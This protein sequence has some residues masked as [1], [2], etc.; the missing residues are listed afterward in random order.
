MATP[1]VTL[2]DGSDVPITSRNVTHQRRLSLPLL[3]PFPACSANQVKGSHQFVELPSETHPLKSLITTLLPKLKPQEGATYAKNL[4]T[5]DHETFLRHL[6]HLKRLATI[7]YQDPAAVD[8]IVDFVSKLLALKE[9]MT[10]D[11]S[12]DV[13]LVE[14]MGELIY[15]LDH[16]P[17][18]LLK[19]LDATHIFSTVKEVRSK[20]D[21]AI[22]E[23]QNRLKTTH[24][25]HTKTG[26]HNANIAEQ[27]A[28][29]TEIAKIL[30][31]TSGILNDALVSRVIHEFVQDPTQKMY[32][33]SSL[34]AG[35]NLIRHSVTIRE[36][37]EKITVRHPI[38][39]HTELVIASTL[40]LPP[41]TE[42][43]STHARQCALSALLTRLRQGMSGSC[44]A[45]FIAI[46]LQSA[47]PE[48]VLKDFQQLFDEQ[49][50]VRELDGV[51][52]SFPYL[53]H[54]GHE[55][56][57]Q[58]IAIDKRGNVLHPVSLNGSLADAPGFIAVCEQFHIDNPQKFLHEWLSKQNFSGSKLEITIEDL[59]GH[60]GREATSEQI[61][62]AQGAFT[63]FTSH[64]LLSIWE[65]SLAAMSEGKKGGLLQSALINTIVYPILKCGKLKEIPLQLMERIESL[66]MQRAHYLYD[67][68][69]REGA[70]ILYDSLGLD[71]VNQWERIDSQDAFKIFVQKL[72]TKV[73]ENDPLMQ[74]ISSYL[75]S[76]KF[77]TRIL[78]KYNPSENPQMVQLTPWITLL[79]NDPLM[80]MQVYHQNKMPYTLHELKPITAQDLLETLL[81][82]LQKMADN[83]KAKFLVEPDL[84][85]PMRIPGIHAFSLL[86]NHASLQSIY[87]YDG[88]I[89]TWLQKTV[90]PT[91]KSFERQRMTKNMRD[92]VIEYTVQF[93][94]KENRAKFL[95]QVQAFPQKL[96]IKEFRHLIS[97]SIHDKL[98]PHSLTHDKMRLI[99]AKLIQVLPK[100]LKRTWTD[101]IIHIADSNW[102]I[103]G[104]DIH[105]GIG[106][107]PGS[108]EIELMAILEDGTLYEFME[109][110]HYLKGHTWEVFLP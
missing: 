36:H 49:H 98:P 79:G 108:G 101:S 110:T 27:H 72:L 84:L 34:K 64:P 56:L 20:F 77:I 90:Q 61:K 2:I 82:K 35:L 28:I 94:E 31:P 47:S 5:L 45:S 10:P 67:T 18:T 107:N 41:K 83:K 96:T 105:Y 74:K 53:L 1:P 88:T 26:L 103:N 22:A 43:T 71:D 92:D 32:Y 66:L 70:F 93:I 30:L 29:P 16:D 51:R 15:V 46:E 48:Q 63:A 8:K 75:S 89:K 104:Q 62:G 85:C 91:W 11:H 59:I 58:K 73:L 42:I 60:L 78:R 50:L 52:R 76:N 9:V 106:L 7:K 25:N 14:W 97:E 69:Y 33:S 44:F 6:G 68:S 24:E 99:D 87:S 19:M 102:Q 57:K 3:N 12:I 17:D 38:S 80:V 37:L 95:K 23:I 55:T 65:N 39:K 40:K 54:W 21:Q 109:Q 4:W 86:L 13:D 81:T 100:V